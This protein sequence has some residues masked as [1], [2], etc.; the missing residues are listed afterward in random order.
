[1]AKDGIPGDRP[2][3]V[4]GP[5][6]LATALAVRF[7]RITVLFG[8]ALAVA[9]LVL[10]AARMEFK[11]SR[12][13]LLN[14][15]SCYNRLWLEYIAEFGDRD[16]VVVVVEGPDRPR[17]VA[18]IREVGQALQGDT[19]LFADVLWEVD[20]R[21][22]RRKG[23]YFLDEQE[24]VG[25]LQFVQQARPIVHG[26]WAQLNAATLLDLA[27]RAASEEAPHGG[28]VRFADAASPAL[29]ET[30]GRTVSFDLG[31]DSRKAVT[32]DSA[33]S[34]QLRRLTDSLSAWLA[35]GR[36]YR[37]PWP[38]PVAGISTA[39][40]Q[41]PQF[42]LADGGRM[43]FVLL[44][45]VDYPGEFAGGSEAI[46]ALR[47]VVARIAPSYPGVQIGV[48]GLPVMENDEMRESQSS[49]LRASALSLAGVACLFMAGFGGIR[50]P[51][52]TVVALLT[53]LA[54]SL[55]WI[56]LA[57]GHLNILTMSFGVILIG[58][59]I[60]F[61]IHYV[62]RYLQLRP[63]VADSAAAL[64]QTAA[65]VGPGVV[66]GGLTTA[67]AFFTAGLTDFT[68]V[69][70]LGIVAGG[71]ILL[72]LAGAVVLLPALLQLVDRNRPAAAPRPLRIDTFVATP[73]RW[74]WLT[75]A[76]VV[77][78]TTT[79]GVGVRW[80]RYDHNLLNLQAEGLQ[81]VELEHRLLADTDE[82]VWYALSICDSPGQLIERKLAFA[83]LPTVQRTDDLISRLP[84]RVGSKQPLVEQIA[85]ATAHIP[86]AADQIP[87]PDRQQ[88]DASLARAEQS[89]RR[90]EQ[91][92]GWHDAPPLSPLRKLL[93][94]LPPREFNWRLASWQ[95][96]VAADLLRRLAAIQQ[97]AGDT[98]PPSPDDL[99][100]SLTSRYI[101]AT[102][103]H[104]LKV[105][106]R[107]NIWDMHDLESFVHQVRSVDPRATGK[108]LQTYEASR[109]MQRSYVAAAI[110]S[111]VAVLIVLVLDFR[112]L[113]DCLLALVPLAAGM[114][115]MFGLMA[116]LDIP[117]NPANMIVLPLILGI[118]IDDGVHLVHDFRTQSG[119]YRTGSSTA[120]AVLLTSLTS[121]V[122]FG[123]LMIAAHRG[124]ES[125]GRVL[126]IGISCCLI[127]SL[128]ILPTLL[129]IVSRWGESKRLGCEIN[130]ESPDAERTATL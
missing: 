114:V 99:P 73:A 123:S 61:G 105:Y 60:D 28:Q 41:A 121:M 51:L 2:S 35:D 11:T 29:S 88:F 13:D 122:G 118:G 34:K 32:D 93:L 53:A 31:P 22:L 52:M 49:T 113:G 91:L 57:L 125:L 44:H 36:T 106:A 111:L 50:H 40:P 86:P 98:T 102:G 17:V 110:Y 72:C 8:L 80:L 83:R 108:P 78:I 87:L 107:G 7:P 68:G 10:A 70:E 54:W 64:R 18:A 79:L 45:V 6:R 94:E 81:S 129:T 21:P 42:L 97:A 4:A 126:V 1:M 103:K 47:S 109:Q 85:A 74:P 25:A 23:L 75:L 3:L 30:S 43:G 127:S 95:Q 16:D 130:R 19:R 58:L 124:L 48:T 33:S 5:L 69:A 89:L 27:T 71:G 77:G 96:S 9:A 104:L 38:E 115:Q 12:L 14:L 59:G 56:T 119:R 65:S 39:A 20:P 128:V 112:H 101:G 116:W 24:L 15:K 90:P 67:L 82:S 100:A 62:A 63:A 46:D 120:T 84:K 55:G 37:S 66:A 76:I 92:A 117:L 26:D